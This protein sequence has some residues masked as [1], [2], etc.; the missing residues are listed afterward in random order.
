MRKRHWFII[1][2]L[3]LLCDQ[4]DG[5]SAFTNAG[6]NIGREE[7]QKTITDFLRKELL[8]SLKALGAPESE[9][10]EMFGVPIKGS[11]T[12]PTLLST[13][14]RYKLLSGEE[15]MEQYELDEWIIK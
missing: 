12:W 15:K 9:P 5:S 7:M 10:E 3:F 8:A 14:S 11:F 13:L 2:F 6:G 4:S 1:L